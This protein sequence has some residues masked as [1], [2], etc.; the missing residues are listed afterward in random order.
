[1]NNMIQNRI[2]IKVKEFQDYFRKNIEGKKILDDK[3]SKE[4]EQKKTEHHQFIDEIYK[5]N[6]R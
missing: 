2:D 5:H 6:K 3:T 1:M 4:F